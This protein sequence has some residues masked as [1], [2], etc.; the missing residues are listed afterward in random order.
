[1]RIQYK[2][3]HPAYYFFKNLYDGIISIWK[4]MKITASYIFKKPET[5]EYPE[6]K[7][8]IPENYRAVHKIDQSK[9]SSCGSCI[10]ACPTECITMGSAGQGHDTILTKFEVN[11][12]NCM[13]CGLCTE[14]C[15]SKA[16][17]F[18]NEAHL[19][20]TKKDNTKLSLI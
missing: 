10:R 2:K 3:K 15:V 19:T 11:Y 8:K 14:T 7:I 17:T 20:T 9:C 6:Q 5:V 13:F 16:L 18:H 4:G 12:A 1:M